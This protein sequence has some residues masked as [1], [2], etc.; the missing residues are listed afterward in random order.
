MFI[1]EFVNRNIT[2]AYS[3][4]FPSHKFMGCKKESM[5]MKEYL[6]CID[7]DNI[8]GIGDFAPTEGVY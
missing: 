8:T 3:R 2:S 1:G 4:F 5:A 7:M 6:H